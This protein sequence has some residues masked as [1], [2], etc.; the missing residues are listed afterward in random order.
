MYHYTYKIENIN[1]ESQKKFYIGVRS[2]KVLPELDDYM[3]SSKPLSEDISVYGIKSFV[4][5][6]LNEYP[7][8]E[9]ANLHERLLLESV[10]AAE[11]SEWYNQTDGKPDSYHTVGTV[12]VRRIDESTFFQLPVETY[13]ANKHLYKTATS[14]SVPVILPSGEICRIS[15]KEFENGL[16]THISSGTCVVI[17]ESGERTRIPISDIKATDRKYWSGMI[18]VV[19]LSTGANTCI[20]ASEYDGVRYVNVK[21]GRISVRDNI[22]GQTTTIS[23]DD[24][25][26]N[27]DRYEVVILDKV[28][29]CYDLKGNKVS[30]SSE[31]YQSNRSEYTHIHSKTIAAYDLIENR[32]VRISTELFKSD[33]A[34]YKNVGHLS[35]VTIYDSTGTKQF[36]TISDFLELCKKENLPMQVLQQSYLRGGI[37]IYSSNRGK[38]KAKNN[39]KENFI[40]WYAI[41]EKYNG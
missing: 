24:Y 29:T 33:K 37:P 22:T 4:K 8:R 25:Y 28:I 34:R 1:P 18:P 26:N 2:S 23:C 39:G 38:V 12:T 36:E 11:S 41:K 16:Y 6:I 20:P 30:I 35:K 13:H 17:R 31:T 5:E 7:T 3:G 40:G 9:I 32:V 10:K 21:L 15:T 14:D 19:D 27:L